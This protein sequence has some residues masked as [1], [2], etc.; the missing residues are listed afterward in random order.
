MPRSTRR[1]ATALTVSMVAAGVPGAARE[2]RLRSPGGLPPAVEGAASAIR[3]ELIRAHMR[4]LADDLLEGRGPGTRGH[5]LAA[6][7]VATELEAT[8]VE[9]SGDS[10]TYFQ[11][12]PLVRARPRESECRIVSAGEDRPLAYGQDYVVFADPTGK[13][14]AVEA[15]V[16]FVGYG[17]AAP[18]EH[19]DD[20]AGIDV[21][22]KIVAYFAGAPASFSEASRALYDDPLGKRE[23]ATAHGAVGVVQLAAADEASAWGATVLASKVGTMALLDETERRRPAP[24][25]A[26]L[27][28]AGLEAVFAENMERLREAVAD[29]AAGRPHSFLATRR[30]T[31]EARA[32]R[33]ALSSENVVAVQRG[34]DARLAAEHVVYT[35]HLDHLGIGPA[36]DG[37][38]IYNGAR[39]NASGVAG[40]LAVAR[41]FAALPGR[42]RR[43]V[44]FVATTAEEPGL[45]GST[46]FVTHPPMPLETIVAAINLDGLAVFWPLLDAAGWGARHSDLGAVFAEA[47]R[48][49]GLAPT[50]PPDDD[51]V[52]LRFSDQASFARRGIP[53]MW[54]VYGDK[55]RDPHASPPELEARWDRSHTPGDDMTLPFDFDSSARLARV[56]FL[57]GYLV[58]D[59]APRPRWLPGAPPAP[60]P[61]GRARNAAAR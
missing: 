57:T 35:A 25:L 39:D 5:R 24:D 19:Y 58:A 51:K 48:A 37:D 30:L 3:P 17:V 45:L 28:A 36:V 55:S 13:D 40:L 41:A 1:L 2:P 14:A 60:D 8:G 31:V 53:S 33:E 6:L 56:A 7:Y 26:H 50:L 23:T 38:S 27:S 59:R 42:P 46:H 12:V 10:G 61:V 44:V 54:L 47:A 49:G 29:I 34:S 4:F 11:R 18:R 20:Y 16:A 43:S 9:P 21:A 22:G 15:A 52:L 32:D